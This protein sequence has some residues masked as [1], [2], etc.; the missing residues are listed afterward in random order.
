MKIFYSPQTNN[1]PKVEFNLEKYFFL[2]EG[3]SVPENSHSVY[4][5]VLNW[6]NTIF[7]EQVITADNILLT[8]N[9]K[10]FSTTS[11]KYLL[12]IIT[13]FN[14]FCT[15][16]SIS[17]VVEWYFHEEDED[18]LEAGEIMQKLSEINFKFKKYN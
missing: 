14:H 8:V 13:Q 6:I 10:Y 16:K 11:A 12:K 9:V 18:M 15:L 1:T 7:A 2:I 4:E 3:I 17:F 5:P